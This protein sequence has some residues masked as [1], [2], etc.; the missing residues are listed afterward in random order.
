MPSRGPMSASG[1]K[2]TCHCKPRCLLLTQSRH[3]QIEWAG[4]ELKLQKRVNAAGSNSMDTESPDLI[5]AWHDLYVM[6]GASSAAL[7]GLLFVATSN[8]KGARS[9]YSAV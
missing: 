3:C 4:S 7:M 1:V 9:Q 6:L 5:E 2:R 8:C